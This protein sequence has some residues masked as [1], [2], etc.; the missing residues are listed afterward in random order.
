[1]QKSLLQAQLYHAHHN[2][3]VE[4]LPFWLQWAQA[5]DGPILELGCGTGRVLRHLTKTKKTIYGIDH[6]AHMLALLQSHL[7]SRLQKRVH[8]LQADFRAFH[9]HKTFKLI[10]LPCNTLSTLT[11][12]AQRKALICVRRHLSKEG[13]FVVSLPNPALLAD[14]PDKGEITLEET[15]AHPLSGEPVQVSSDWECMGETVVFYWHYDH[16][17][18]NGR[19]AR[20]TVSTKQYCQSLQ[21]IERI[22]DQ[23]GLTIA[24]KYGDYDKTSYTLDS[25][26][27]I[28]TAQS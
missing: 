3:A 20:S 24:K 1:M 18:E 11:A 15:F 25:P 6:D 14:L 16:L 26:Y 4:D 2:Q 23:A 10:L 19:V 17:L 9:L 28:V 13:I 7:P 21:E 27:L 12:R 8:L 22:F 5:Q